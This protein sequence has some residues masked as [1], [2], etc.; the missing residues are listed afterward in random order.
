MERFHLAVKLKPIYWLK[1]RG[2]TGKF[3]FAT[4]INRDENLSGGGKMHD[5]V[6]ACR[7][8]AGKMIR[9]RNISARVKLA[10]ILALGMTFEPL[11]LCSDCVLQR[12]NRIRYVHAK[13]MAIPP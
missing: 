3:E 5:R 12:E 13:G 10:A 1:T 4:F 7:Y 2:S 11:L 6:P 8:N 9:N